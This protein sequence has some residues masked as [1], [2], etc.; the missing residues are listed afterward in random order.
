[1]GLSN[2]ELREIQSRTETRYYFQGLLRGYLR[3]RKNMTP[4]QNTTD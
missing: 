2:I 1:M 4:R 3:R